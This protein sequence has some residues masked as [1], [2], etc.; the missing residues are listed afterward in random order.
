MGLKSKHVC[1]ILH[2]KMN[3]FQGKIMLVVGGVQIVIVCD[4]TQAILHVN[5]ESLFDVRGAI[6]C[7]FC[8]LSVP[9][10]VLG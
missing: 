9:V 10:V 4:V 6:I 8:S 3:T 2:G 5:I 1:K 7:I